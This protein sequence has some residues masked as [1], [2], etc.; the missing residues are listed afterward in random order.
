MSNSSTPANSVAVV[1][2]GIVGIC[3]ALYLQRSG[4]SVTIYDKQECAQGASKGNAGHF[5]TEQVFPLADMNLL[6]QVPKMLLDPLG[7]FRIK[8]GYLFQAIPWFSRFLVNM[9]PSRFNN[10]KAALKALNTPAMEAYQPL[11]KAAGLDTLFTKN[12]SLLVSER[13]ERAALQKVYN[14]FKSNGVAVELLSQSEVRHIAP[15][16]NDKVQCGLFFKDVGHTVEPELLAKGLFDFFIEQGGKFVKGQVSAVTQVDNTTCINAELPSSELPSSELQTFVHKH[17]VIACGAWSK[18]LVAQLGYK[19]PLDTERGYHLMLPNNANDLPIPVA[20]LERKFIMTP[21]QQGLR[22]AGTVEFAGLDAPADAARAHALLPHARSLLTPAV[23]D[24]ASELPNWMGFRPSLPDSLP[25]IGRAP[26][27]NQIYF[28]FGHQHLG[29][30]Q[31]AITGKLIS[32]LIT[33]VPVS[34]NL[35]PYCISRFQ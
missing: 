11:I 33:E 29:L 14:S 23:P 6:P 20:S 32:E 2:A 5:A 30:T 31:A 27:H 15:N 12:G 17:A 16:L 13:P 8:M 28:A 1:G 24:N 18:P 34:V 22:L 10:N 3:T 25:V 21:M 9:L 7:P 19:V 4:L 35:S 26:V